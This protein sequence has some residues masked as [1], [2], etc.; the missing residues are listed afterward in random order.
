MTEWKTNEIKTTEKANK[1][2]KKKKTINNS[3]L[4]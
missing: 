4:W 3:K 1:D 2:K